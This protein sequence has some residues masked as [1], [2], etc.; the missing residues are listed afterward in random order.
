MTE[1]GLTTKSE[2]EFLEEYADSANA[3][4]LHKFFETN[5]SED[6]TPLTTKDFSEFYD[7][8]LKKKDFLEEEPS[9]SDS[10]TSVS[11][12]TEEEDD[13]IYIPEDEI[14]ATEE[15]NKEN[16]SEIQLDENVFSQTDFLLDGKLY[17][18]STITPVEVIE[19]KTKFY[20]PKGYTGVYD[21]KQDMN[22]ILNPRGE[23]LNQISN[24]IQSGEVKLPTKL[25]GGGNI[26]MDALVDKYGPEYANYFAQIN[27]DKFNE[28]LQNNEIGKIRKLKFTN[29]RRIR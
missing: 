29:K 7:S 12:S 6:G 2:G 5:E 3:V 14:E 15:I 1:E 4:R 11:E 27:P 10:E 24:D 23:K 20:L 16:K 19:G 22:L 28:L 18:E 9:T 26:T 13:D 17:N 21:E 25:F 8:Y